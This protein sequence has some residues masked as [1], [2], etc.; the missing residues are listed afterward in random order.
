MAR[1]PRPGPPEPPRRD[2]VGIGVL[3]AAVL[4]FAVGYW[5]FPLVQHWLANQD[6]IASGRVNCGR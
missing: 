1:S 2:L 5:L 3:L 6:C 4:L